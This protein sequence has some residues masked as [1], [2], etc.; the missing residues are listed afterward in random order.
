MV[1]APETGG[2]INMKH[3]FIIDSY[4][5]ETSLGFAFCLC[6]DLQRQISRQDMF[7]FQGILGESGREW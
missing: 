7:K 3:L 5:L 2:D 6:E 1:D 4:S